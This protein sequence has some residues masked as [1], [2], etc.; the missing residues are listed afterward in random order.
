MKGVRGITERE[1]ERRYEGSKG[2][3]GDRARR[4]RGR[5]WRWGEGGDDWIERGRECPSLLPCWSGILV[6]R[7]RP[8]SVRRTTSDEGP[9]GH[10]A[11]TGAGD[12]S[13]G[14]GTGT[15]RRFGFLLISFIAGDSGL[16]FIS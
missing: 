16:Y 6:T 1:R 11:V 3:D 7:K 12:V 10:L 4:G 14:T 5:R 13:A 8:H 2:K 15:R 9:D